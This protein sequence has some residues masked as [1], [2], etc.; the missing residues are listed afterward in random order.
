MVFTNRLLSIPMVAAVWFSFGSVATACSDVACLNG[1]AEMR[2]TFTLRV[3]HANR[4]LAG[5][6]V[7]IFREGNEKSALVTDS[8]GT[9]YIRNLDPGEY[10]LKADFLGT[11]VVY[12]CFHV[13][14]RSTAKAKV[15][16]SY[17][18]GEEAP[19]TARI[20]GVLFD[21]QPADRENPLI[22][23]DVPIAG[24]N[25][26]LADPLTGAVYLTNSDRDGKFA[27]DATPN[28]TYALHLDGGYAGDRAYDATDK[29]I[30]VSSSATRNWLVLRRIQADGGSC[31]GTELEVRAN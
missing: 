16:L 12:T 24:A 22:R 5:V 2:R 8:S 17:S 20:S 25:V 23:S 28:G 29:I 11:D 3:T 13:N 7:H 27:F 18:W 4:A 31:G 9:V 15:H 10:W 21:S 14:G 30:T 26:R 1:G 6:V 19:A